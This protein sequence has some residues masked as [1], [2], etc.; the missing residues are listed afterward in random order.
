MGKATTFKET[1][2]TIDL[3]N[4]RFNKNIGTRQNDMWSTIFKTIKKLDTDEAGNILTN[5]KNLKIL[6]TLRGDISKTIITPQYK[7]DLKRFLG[8][9]NELKG[10]ND[11]YYKAIASGTLNANKQVFK[12]VTNISIDATKNSLLESGINNAIIQP[13]ETILNQSITSG[14]SFTD[15]NEALRLDIL[16]DSEKLGKL[17]RYS[18]QITTDSLNQFNANYNQT[19]SQDL[20]LEFYY[21]N[22]AIKETSRTYCIDRVMEGRYFHKNEVE[23]SASEEWAGKISGTNSSSIFI[24]RGGYNC[25]HQWLAVDR[26]AVPSDVI[27]RNIEKGCLSLAY[28]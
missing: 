12:A 5:T 21:Y 11:T 7:K 8:G 18:K 25:G 4:E 14:A 6:R 10:I 9:F 2:D 13:V 27:A 20:G 23:D 24:N 19:V 16:G 3:F 17:E 28:W 15:M 1:R 22:G 26:L